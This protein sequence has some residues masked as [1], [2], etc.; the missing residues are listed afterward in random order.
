MPLT[1]LPEKFPVVDFEPINISLGESTV[2]LHILVK[3]SDSAVGL[4]KIIQ[5]RLQVFTQRDQNPSDPNPQEQTWSEMDLP[6]SGN[7]LVD[8]RIY[9][10]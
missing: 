4:L 10:P 8:R 1:S 9:A 5:K 3:G 7:A 2:L 6:D